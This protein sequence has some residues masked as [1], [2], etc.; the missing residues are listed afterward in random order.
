[1][2]TI[3]QQATD[4]RSAPREGRIGMQVQSGPNDSK[5]YAIND[6]PATPQ[7]STVTV[8][9]AT[10]GKTYP[11]VVNNTT[12]SYT[13]SGSPD[14]AEVAEGLAAAINAEPL[15][16]GAVIAAW[17]SGATFTITALIPGTAFTAT[18]DDAQLSIAATTANADAAAIEFGRAVI[19]TGEAAGGELKCGTAAS[20]LLTAQ[21]D[22]LTTPYVASVEYTVAVSYR[23]QD[24]QVLSTAD[25]DQDTT[26]TNLAAAL[27][28]VLPANSV[29]VTDN[30]S[31]SDDATALIFT[32]EIAGEEFS[33]SYG[34]SDD[35]AS[36][37][38]MALSSTK[39]TSTSFVKSMLG[40]SLYSN[41]PA[42]TVGGATGQYAARAG[43]RF[44]EKGQIWVES[45][46][47][48]SYGEDVYVELGSG[49]DTGK[50]FNT[51]S[52]TRVLLPSARWIKDG[53]VA[54]DSIA[55]IELQ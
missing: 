28:A 34:T 49:S 33:V 42:A 39:S 52:S 21:V 5:G 17:T 20:A 13:A 41:D 7:L 35:G 47:A 16:R 31:G 30:D 44:L 46:Q 4:V 23:G 9:G 8:S 32:A 10:A 1:M 26:I 25:T 50:F 53:S 38:A 48:V 36:H 29:A 19:R 43:V 27:N 14:T 12:C 51:A 6:S 40:T 54:G 37:P 22:T 11:V 15:V 55:A 3:S 24:Y 2:S 45:D 18:E